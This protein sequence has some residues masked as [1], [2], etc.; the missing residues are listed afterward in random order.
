MNHAQNYIE[1]HDIRPKGLVSLIILFFGF[2]PLLFYWLYCGQVSSVTP[3]Q[4]Q[5]ILVEKTSSAVLVDVRS[6]SDYE[7]FHI[8]GAVL[9]PFQEIMELKAPAQMPSQLQN[10]MLLLICSGGL[11]S[12]TATRHLLELGLMNVKNVRG[13]IQEWIGYSSGCSGGVCTTASP[14]SGSSCLSFRISPLHEKVIAVASGFIIKPTYSILSLI[15]VIILWRCKSPDLISLRWAMIFFFIG[16]NF[17]AANY[18]FFADK[19]YLTEYLHSYGM[20]LSFGFTTYAVMDGID[21]RIL[22]L[23]APDHKCAALQLCRQCVKYEKVPCKLRRVFYVMIPALAIVALMPLF[24]NQSTT[25]YTTMIFG[26]CFHYARRLIYQ[27]FEM[28]YCPLAA[29]ILLSTSWLVL[30]FKKT[31]S[32]PWAKILF[33]AGIGPLGFG[34]FRTILTT[35]YSQNLVWFAFWE[36]ATELMFIISV[37]FVLWIFRKSLFVGERLLWENTK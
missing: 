30:L 37:C 9:W 7:S 18:L 36:E 27:H 3:K 5:D 28:Q 16:E 14:E 8:N 17:C 2:L 15:L 10:K 35:M 1:N 33:A 22:F 13:G 6:S 11:Q 25:S 24:A 34:M 20:L 23:S 29:I 31:R 12:C 26:T 4:A 19:S 32:L 21:R